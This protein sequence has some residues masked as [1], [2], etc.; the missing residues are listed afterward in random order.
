MESFDKI[1][2][3][4]TASTAVPLWDRDPSRDLSKGLNAVL[5]QHSKAKASASRDIGTALK[6][7][8]RMQA[9]L[10]GIV[11]SNQTHMQSDRKALESSLSEAVSA[12]QKGK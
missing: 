2:A 4:I 6:D 12:L 11:K 3:D 8:P 9:T 5:A 7:I 1:C 10:D